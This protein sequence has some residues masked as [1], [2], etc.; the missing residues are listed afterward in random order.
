MGKFGKISR[1][2]FRHLGAE[3]TFIG[4]PDNPTASGQSTP[5]EAEILR[6]NTITEKTKIGGIIGGE[7]VEHSIGIRYYNNFLPTKRT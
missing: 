6:L 4:L 7:Q 1:I 2:L 3:A 5:Q